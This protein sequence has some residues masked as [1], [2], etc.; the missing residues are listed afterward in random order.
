MALEGKLSDFAFAE[1]LQLDNNYQAITVPV[2]FG[3]KSRG[4]PAF[5]PATRNT[6]VAPTLP[7]P[8]RRGSVRPAA[9][10][11]SRPKGI[12]PMR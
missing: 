7:E 2:T 3:A 4:L 5:F 1:I 9:F 12:E 11:S 6:F 8:A 10:A